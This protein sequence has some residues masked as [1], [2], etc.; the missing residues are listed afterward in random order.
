[1]GRKAKQNTSMTVSSNNP[2]EEYLRDNIYKKSNFLIAAKYKSTLMENKILAI[3]LAHA[4]EMYEETTED[5][6]VWV[7]KLHASEI[8]KIL[9]VN[10]GSLYE[11]LKDT[12]E[13]LMSRNMGYIDPEKK[14]FDYI[15][16]VQRARYIK[17]EF[18]IYYTPYFRKYIR[19]VQKNYTEFNLK[20]MVSFKSDYAFRLYELI[21]S[22]CY[23]INKS[24]KSDN[25]YLISFGLSE[26]MFDLGVID[27]STSEVIK[28]LKNENAPDYDKAAEKA[29]VKKKR[30]STSWSEFRRQALDIAVKEINNNQNINMN[31]KYDTMRKGKGGKVTTIIFTATIGKELL[32]DEQ[33]IEEVRTLNEE[34]KISFL[35][36]LGD[37]IKEGLKI[38][39]LKAIAEAANYNLALI[40]EKYNLS[41][42]QNIDNLVGWLISAIKEDY[43]K[44]IST[45]KS[46]K[47]NYNFEESD[48]VYDE[49]L[50]FDN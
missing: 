25:T 36:D 7:S 11:N 3:S 6:T 38:K 43:Q 27:A 30:L 4:N 47:N 2:I 13:L 48:T 32:L 29:T 34:E 17:G 5:G 24:A 21:K 37:I 15:N 20:I 14:V 40:E 33:I 28:I 31:L 41:K 22:Q 1:M 46:L 42:K 39:D 49:E 45:I 10:G 12:A 8:R 44:P 23:Y 35:D 26:L 9:G 50:L 18:Y 19:Q 16:F